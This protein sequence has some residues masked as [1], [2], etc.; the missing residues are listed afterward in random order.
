MRRWKRARAELEQQGWV[1]DYVE[2]RQAETLEV[3]HAGEQ[4]LVVMVAARLGRTRL[5][6][7]I[8]ILRKA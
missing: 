5:I 6:D 3:A 2:I 8:D 4:H 1:V 7:N